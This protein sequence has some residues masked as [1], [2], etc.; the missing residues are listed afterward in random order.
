MGPT[1]TDGDG[2]FGDVCD[3]PGGAGANNCNQLPE[4]PNNNNGGGD[5]S[6]EA[7]EILPGENYVIMLNLNGGGNNNDCAIGDLSINDE[8]TLWIHVEGGGSTYETLM[9]T[10]KTPGAELV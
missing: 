10:D 5:A 6:T 9:I 7:L 3:G 4:M 1:D 8:I 2:D